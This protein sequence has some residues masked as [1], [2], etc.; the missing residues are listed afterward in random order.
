MDTAF[1]LLR[2]PWQDGGCCQPRFDVTHYVGSL[3]VYRVT[4][5]YSVPPF[6]G[7]IPVWHEFSVENLSARYAQSS[8]A[9]PNGANSRFLF[10][11]NCCLP[12]DTPSFF[13]FPGHHETMRSHVVEGRRCAGA[14][15]L[16]RDLELR[17]E[18][19]GVANAIHDTIK[20]LNDDAA[21]ELFVCNIVALAAVVSCVRKTHIGCILVF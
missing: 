5:L 1:L 17:L 20:L 11:F 13:S 10:F 6:L 14:G 12:Q 4:H 15:L 18:L 16:Q 7:L 2:S 19:P 8:A 9:P 3:C 21:L